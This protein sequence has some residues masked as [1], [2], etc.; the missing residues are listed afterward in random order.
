MTGSGALLPRNEDIMDAKGLASVAECIALAEV[1]LTCELNGAA[2]I[3]EAL[4]G[5]LKKLDME[6][7]DASG[8]ASP[9]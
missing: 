6:A 3:A 7:I 5:L 4:A 8:F 9:T 1:P 2:D